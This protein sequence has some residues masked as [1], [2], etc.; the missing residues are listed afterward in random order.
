MIGK[1][2]STCSGWKSQVESDREGKG[3]GD[4]GKGA[5]KKTRAPREVTSVKSYHLGVNYDE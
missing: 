4:G 5:E 3:R 1:I 2:S